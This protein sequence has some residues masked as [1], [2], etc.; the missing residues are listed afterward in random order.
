MSMAGVPCHVIQ[1]GN[2]RLPW[3][4]QE[5]HAYLSDP[6]SNGVT[7]SPCS[8]PR[9]FHPKVQRAGGLDEYS[10]PEFSAALKPY[11]VCNFMV[12]FLF[13]VAYLC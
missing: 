7:V 5:H 12:F 8:C 13:S 11:K 9:L 4:L 10:Y 6:L 3:K 1:R 2:T